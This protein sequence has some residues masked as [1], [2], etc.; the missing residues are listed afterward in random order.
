MAMM[1]EMT[2][3]IMGVETNV[4]PWNCKQGLPF[5]GEIP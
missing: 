2:K 3:I 4:I 1:G 5:S